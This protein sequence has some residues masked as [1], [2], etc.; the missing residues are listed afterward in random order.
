MT[1]KIQI[2][3]IGHNTNGCTDKHSKVAYETGYHER[4]K[5]LEK[6]VKED[7]FAKHVPMTIV[8]TENDIEDFLENSINSGCEGLMLKMMDKPNNCCHQQDG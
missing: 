6:I 2:L 4:R 7:D 3:I 8:K 5:L 1:K